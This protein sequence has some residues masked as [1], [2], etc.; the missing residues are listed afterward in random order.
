MPSEELVIFLTSY[1]KFPKYS[2]TQNICCNHP[3]SWLRQRFFRMIH[4]KDAAGTANSIDPDQTA[5]LGAVWSGSALFA[6][7]CLSENLGKL[8]FVCC[9][10]SN[11]PIWRDTHWKVLIQTGLMQMIFVFF[12]TC[13]FQY[14][15]LGWSIT[16]VTLLI[17]PHLLSGL[18]HPYQLD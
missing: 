4:P 15:L 6:Q 10:C 14:F 16:V 5:P 7:T 2:D 3:K 18:F 12:I 9:C 13:T 1:R 17:N 8:Q 11:S